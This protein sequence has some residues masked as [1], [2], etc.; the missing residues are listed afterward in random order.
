MISESQKQAPPSSKSTLLLWSSLL[1]QSVSECS[2]NK[3]QV[4]FL[5]LLRKRLDTF[6]TYSD[7]KEQIQ[8]AIAEYVTNFIKAGCSCTKHLLEHLVDLY[9]TEKLIIDSTVYHQA[10]QLAEETFAEHSLLPSPAES[11]P[12][13]AKPALFSKSTLYHACICSRAVNETNAGEY[14]KFFKDEKLVPGHALKEI[15]ISRSKQERYLIARQEDSTYYI[16][17]QGEPDIT[18]WPKKYSSFEHGMIMIIESCC[19][20]LSFSSLQVF[21]LKQR[22]FLFTLSQNS[23]TVGTI[24]LL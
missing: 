14:Q 9:D 16:A 11:L 3:L 23:S 6:N 21:W 5:D 24:E 7:K 22:I 19:C 20:N 17:F 1:P 10:K 12:P 13:S 2:C 8:L 4:S 18:Q 15:S